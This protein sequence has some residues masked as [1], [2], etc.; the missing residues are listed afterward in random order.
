MILKKK[1]GHWFYPIAALFLAVLMWQL[2][3]TLADIPIY[4]LP[5]P[6]DTVKALLTDF[7]MIARH[8]I[9]T[10]YASLLGFTLSVALA[11][12]LAIA[13]DSFGVVKKSLYPILIVS[14]TVPTIAIT[15]LLII[16]F[17]FG[18]LPK[19]LIIVLMCFFP[20]CISLVDG[21]DKVDGDYLRLFRSIKA[22]RWQT[23]YHLKLPH[24]MVNLFS[25]LKIAATYMLMAAIIGEWQGGT[26]GLGVYM[27]RTKNA[28]ALDKMFASIL[29]IVL[30]SVALIY[31]INKVAS[32]VNHWK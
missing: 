11:F 20:I 13:M 7:G 28:Y 6:L 2:V 24:A 23:F 4:I 17:G 9:A 32:R 1:T 21:F 19:I 30:I 14:Q 12:I 15:P 3:V 22:N 27:V 16:W 26:D 29:V 10:L 8:L 5:S 25:G 18:V 31:L